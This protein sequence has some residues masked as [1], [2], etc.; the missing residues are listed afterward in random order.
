MREAS[1]KLCLI[2]NCRLDLQIT[3][4]SRGSEP[5][6]NQVHRIKGFCGSYNSVQLQ[7]SRHH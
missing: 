1:T 2:G 7:A 6:H 3:E 5:D 4:K